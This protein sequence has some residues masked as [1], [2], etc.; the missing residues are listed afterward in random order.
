MALAVWRCIV[1][2]VV[3]TVAAVSIAKDERRPPA[4]QVDQRTFSTGKPSILRRVVE[5]PSELRALAIRARPVSIDGLGQFRL[6]VVTLI[7]EV[8]CFEDGR[9]DRTQDNFPIGNLGVRGRTAIDG[10]S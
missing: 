5:G 4:R 3:A 8:A 6:D 2:G 1:A 7:G 9:V 10:S